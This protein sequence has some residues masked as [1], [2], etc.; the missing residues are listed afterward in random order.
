M[1][2]I[3][4]NYTIH[5]INQYGLQVIVNLEFDK[6][7]PL[8]MFDVVKCLVKENQKVQASTTLFLVFFPSKIL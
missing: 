5:L 2:R 4:P 3:Y 1:V 8:S 7:N 6:N